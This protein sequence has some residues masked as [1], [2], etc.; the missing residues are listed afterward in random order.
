MRLLLNLIRPLWLYFY[1]AYA[2]RGRVTAG[3]RFYIG[4][5]SKVWAPTR[6]RI[7]ANV[8]VGKLCTI[9]C[10]GEI[11]DDVMIGN[12]VG[13][14]GRYDHDF[15]AIGVSVRN[16]PWIGDARVRAATA[17]DRVEIGSDVWIGY[18]AIILSGVRIGRGAVIGAGSVVT[19]DVCPYVIVAGNPA[20]KIGVRFS[21]DAI[22]KHEDA[23]VLAGDGL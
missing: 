19:R 23:V 18:G 5:G 8:Y 20:R 22:T 6:L 4:I 17:T 10:D 1:K 2:V 9:E 14:V 16:A 13:I 15:R 21:A 3:P 7:G 11:G 12:A